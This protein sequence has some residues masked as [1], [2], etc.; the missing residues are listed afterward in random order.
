MSLDARRKDKHTS[1]T[2]WAEIIALLK[3]RGFTPATME[4]THQ[5]VGM[6]AL[7]VFHHSPQGPALE[8]ETNV[9]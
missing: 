8:N 2:L 5:K 4:Q 6:S 3:M 7:I 9:S 1:P